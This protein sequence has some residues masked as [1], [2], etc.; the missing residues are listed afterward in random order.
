[1][2]SEVKKVWV[3]ALRS[4]NYKQTQGTLSSQGE[5]CCLG[6]LCDLYIKEHECKVEEYTEEKTGRRCLK[7]DNEPGVL[8]EKVMHWAG[9]KQNNPVV[10]GQCLALLND[11]GRTFPEIADMIEEQL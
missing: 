11:L 7:Y 9:L 8:P 4:G 10:Q 3:D 5:F 6:V 1:M 2:N